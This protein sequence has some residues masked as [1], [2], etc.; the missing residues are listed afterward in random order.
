MNSITGRK[1]EARGPLRFLLHIPVP[2][3]YVL[4]YFVGV[5]LQQLFPLE[6]HNANISVYIRMAGALLF[7]AGAIIAGWS[8][9][10]FLRNRTTTVPGQES[11]KLIT[12]SPYR[13]SRNPMYLGLTLAYLGEAG[14]LGQVWPVFVLPLVLVY[15]NRTVIPL[16][17]NVLKKVFGGEYESYRKKVNRWL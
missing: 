13:V 16:E 4:T 3:V 17:E 6:E 8:L 14:L 1:K 10:I 9:S 11:K 2:W 7:A 12:H 5:G 15:T